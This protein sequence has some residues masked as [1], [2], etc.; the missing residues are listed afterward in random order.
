MTALAKVGTD[1]VYIG[2]RLDTLLRG[3]LIHHPSLYHMPGEA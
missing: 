3:L 2:A 1:E